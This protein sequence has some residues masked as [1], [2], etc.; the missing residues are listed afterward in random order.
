MAMFCNN[1][2]QVDIRRDV[3]F[4]HTSEKQQNKKFELLCKHIWKRQ[5]INCCLACSETC[6]INI[7]IE[8]CLARSRQVFQ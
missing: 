7:E 8:I 5:K 4:L 6:T 1:P 2:L 3:G